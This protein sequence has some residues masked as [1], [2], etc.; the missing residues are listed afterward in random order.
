MKKILLFLMQNFQVQLNPIRCIQIF[1]T[2]EHLQ[3]KLCPD[4]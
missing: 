2:F 1:L 3:V 4:D